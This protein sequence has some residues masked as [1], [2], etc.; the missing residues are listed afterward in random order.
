MKYAIVVAVLTL[1][2]CSNAPV[3]AWEKGD[4]ARQEM[5]WSPD[6]MQAAL[7]DHVATSKEGSSGGIGA[8]GGGCGCY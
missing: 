5:S 8:G 7:R 3:Q 1:A 4:L 6:P 2:G